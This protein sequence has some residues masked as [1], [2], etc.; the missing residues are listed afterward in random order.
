VPP[1]IASAKLLDPNRVGPVRTSAPPVSWTVILQMALRW[2]TKSHAVEAVPAGLG[3]LGPGESWLEEVG[4]APGDG[5]VV[6]TESLP[7]A[8]VSTVKGLSAEPRSRSSLLLTNC[9]LFTT[10]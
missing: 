10:E 3:R 9:W 2:K 6:Q 8:E 7:C 5:P 4:V 1:V